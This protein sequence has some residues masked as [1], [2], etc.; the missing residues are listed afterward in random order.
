MQN[1]KMVHM[2]NQIA[3]YFNAYPPERARAEVLNHF[4]SF[5][6]PRMRAQLVE[7]V[8]GGGEGLYPMVQWAARRLEP[9]DAGER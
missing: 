5:W 3:A 7:Y 8:S 6:E 4:R 2:A 9:R 1:E